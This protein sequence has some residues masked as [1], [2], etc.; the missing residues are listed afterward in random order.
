MFKQ[1][2]IRLLIMN[3]SIISVL[4]LFA[5]SSVYL[6]TYNNIHTTIT[7][8]LY[9]SSDIKWPVNFIPPQM[10]TDDEGLLP[11]DDALQ[12]DKNNNENFPEK[13]ISFNIFTEDDGDI[14]MVQSFFD[15]ESVFY[16][17]ALNE[18]LTTSKTMGQFTLDGNEWAYLVTE[19][20]SEMQ[21]TFIDMTAQQKVLDRLIITFII[22]SILS[23]IAIFIISNFLTNRSIRPIKDAFDKQKAFISDASHELK[24]PLA[25]IR[26]NVDVLI[27][28]K[29]NDEDTKWLNYIKSEVER[30]GRLTNDLLSLTQMEGTSHSDLFKHPVQLNDKIEN[31]LL[32]MD[33]IA[34]EKNIEL[35]YTLA[36]SVNVRGNAEQLVQVV[37]ILLDNALKYTPSGGRIDL[38]LTKSHRHGYI[39]VSNTG[40]GIPSESIPYIFDRFYRVDKSRSRSEGSF[41]L[42]LSIAKAIIDQHNGKISCESIENERT[43]F[44][45]KLPLMDQDSKL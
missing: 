42:G 38:A 11:K 27:S 12:I 4:L 15:A 34:F 28:N 6:M 7:R 44:T 21:Y 1:L 3:L 17:N 26:T 23:L 5:F 33:A 45:L 8:D 31:I 13:F 9:R 30:M 35:N 39:S 22:V 14:L 36:P 43:T 37:M 20:K 29:S 40:E 2:R 10:E 19:R 18:V 25:V 16:T 41:G 32:G 24:T